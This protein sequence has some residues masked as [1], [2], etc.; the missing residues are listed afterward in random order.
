MH[1]SRIYV[2]GSSPGFDPG[3]GRDAILLQEELE[4]SKKRNV[5]LQAEIQRW[6]QKYLEE[7]EHREEKIKN[8][9]KLDAM[10]EE[11][12]KEWKHKYHKMAWFADTYSDELNREIKCRGQQ[13]VDQKLAFDQALRVLQDE[14]DKSKEMIAALQQEIINKNNQ[15]ITQDVKFRK[16]LEDNSAEVIAWRD[17]IV[18]ILMEERKKNMLE[19]KA[20]DDEIVR[21][22][23]LLEEDLEEEYEDAPQEPVK[24]KQ[25][26]GL[27]SE[28]TLCGNTEFDA[29]FFDG[30]ASAWNENKVRKGYGY[31]YKCINPRCDQE[32]EFDF[33][34]C[35]YECYDKVCRNGSCKIRVT[36]KK[37]RG[38]CNECFPTC[39]Y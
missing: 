4:E 23:S 29:A 13:L 34:M 15:L 25:K 28:P 33:D 31:V 8:A 5:K 30:A 39:G 22:R 3:T 19:R 38:F 10:W 1:A 18:K 7:F 11:N 24:K 2:A 12:A 20:A 27:M 26:L 21:L 17:N 36:S 35:C 37:K 6:Q 32:G 16:T 9:R 14:K